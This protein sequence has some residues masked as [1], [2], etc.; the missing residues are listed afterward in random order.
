MYVKYKFEEPS[1]MNSASIQTSILRKKHKPPAE[2]R[3]YG[4]CDEKH[5]VSKCKLSTEAAR[6]LTAPSTLILQLYTNIIGSK[7]KTS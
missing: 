5:Q 6:P 1:G 4:G 3:V 7:T 2:F